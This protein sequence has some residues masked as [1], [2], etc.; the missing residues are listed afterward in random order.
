MAAADRMLSILALFSLDRP[1]WT[2][3]AA[4]AEL[5]LPISTHNPLDA[6]SLGLTLP[7]GVASLVHVLI[8]FYTV[9]DAATARRSVLPATGVIALV[10][11]S[12][13]VVGYGAMQLIGADAIRAADR[14]GNLAMPLLALHLGGGPL[15]GFF[16]AVSFGTILAV[17]SGVVI[18]GAAT[19]SHDLW[20]GLLRRGAGQR[21]LLL[22]ARLTTLALGVVVVLLGLAF[23]GQN[24]AV[25]VGLST[26]IAA[27]TVLPVLILAVFWSRLTAAGA[28]A[29]MLSGVAAST[30]LVWLSP[31]VQVDMLHHAS[32]VLPISNPGIISCPLAFCM[33]VTVSLLGSRERS[34]TTFAAIERRLLLGA[35]AGSQGV[36]S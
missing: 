2:V 17:V 10:Q 30:A 11:L 26:A 12:L 35:R 19:M 29:A 3:E 28:V 1:Q 14:G 13:I 22:V 8:R 18:T 16:S 32:A 20:A 25:L 23:Q 27:S 33:G 21:E 31:L 15:L 34:A 7:A 4:A 5:G 6:L 36:T 9:K 24:L